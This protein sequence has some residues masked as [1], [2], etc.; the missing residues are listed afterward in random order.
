MHGKERV[1]LKRWS[2]GDLVRAAQQGSRAAIEYLLLDYA[3]LQRMVKAR[4]RLLD[5][6]SLASDELTAAARLGILEALQRFDPD[7]DVGFL[8]Y[9]YHFIRGEMIRALYCQSLQRE[10]SAGRPKP[11]LVPLFVESAGESEPT[12][13]GEPFERNDNIGVDPGYAKIDR[14]LSEAAVRT[15][16]AALPAGQRD[17]VRDVF[18]NERSHA[19]TARRRGVSRPAVSRALRRALDRGRRD[20]ADHLECLAA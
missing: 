4:A 8:T 15:F 12:V 5:P 16:V 10:W 17:I 11:K 2:E 1:P 7:R 6:R 20:L 14:A 19:E 13:N 3:P 18:W 9:A